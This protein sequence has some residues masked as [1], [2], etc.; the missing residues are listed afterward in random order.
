M[1]TGRRESTTCSRPG[2]SRGELEAPGDTCSDL[3][4][5]IILLD[6]RLNG[7]RRKMG[8]GGGFRRQDC[9]QLFAGAC[10]SSTD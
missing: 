8:E 5:H 1:S 10:R 9:F 7:R 2:A 4:P 3:I 6:R